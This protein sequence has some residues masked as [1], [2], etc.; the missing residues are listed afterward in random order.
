MILGFKKQFE[1]KIISGSK[2]H[3]IREDPTRRWKPGVKIHA[4]TGVRT[5]NY[6]C[7]FESQCISVQEIE[8]SYPKIA[9]YGNG[10]PEIYI[11]GKY[12]DLIWR[13]KLA[14]RDGFITLDE[15]YDWFNKDFRGVI[16]HWTDLIY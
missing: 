15:F 1:D 14:K 13:Q 6:R 11:D 4:A 16:I 10:Y 8:I 3:T 9:K 7:F 12:C 2:I 5:K